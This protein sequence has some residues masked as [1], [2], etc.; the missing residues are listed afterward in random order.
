MNL[1]SPYR[2]VSTKVRSA[3]YKSRSLDL[4]ASRLYDQN[5]FY[6]VFNKDLYRC[7]NELLI[8][9]PFLTTKRTDTLRPILQHLRRRNIAIT[10]NTKPIE[11]H[12]PYFASQALESIMMLQE[13]G[14]TVLFTGGH[15]RKLAVIDEHILWEGSLNILSQNDSCEIMRRIESVELAGQ[16]RKFVKPLQ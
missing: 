15:H 5:S 13:L 14:A 1:L 16:I 2:Y 7:Q 8:E 10:I 6:Q 11:E 12:D 3:T 9:S 4:L